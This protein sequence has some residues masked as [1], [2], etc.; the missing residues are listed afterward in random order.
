MTR[1]ILLDLDSV[2]LAGGQTFEAASVKPHESTLNA[3]S[4]AQG[5]PGTSDPTRFLCRNCSLRNLLMMSYDIKGYQ[6]SS[7]TRSE[8]YDV[9]ASVSAGTSRAQF[10]AMLRNLLTERFRLA[11]HH[12]SKEMPAYRLV[13]GKNGPKVMKSEATGPFPEDDGLPSHAEKDGFPDPG[14]G[15]GI[16]IFADSHN[17]YRLGAKNISMH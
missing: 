14:P 17:T 9:E 3:R 12:Q 5:G 8:R 11:S 10:R 7:E 4:G 15:S 16:Y 1:S 2:A 13:I 6:L